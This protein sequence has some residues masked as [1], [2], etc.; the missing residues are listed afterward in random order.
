MDYFKKTGKIKKAVYV[1]ENNH[2]TLTDGILPIG[3][4]YRDELTF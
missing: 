1:H 3:W 4:A 2:M